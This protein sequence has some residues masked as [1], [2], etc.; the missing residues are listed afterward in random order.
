[1]IKNIIF[2][3]VL[4][5]L[6]ASSGMTA[7]VTA[8]KYDDLL[9]RKLNLEGNLENCTSELASVKAA[10]EEYLYDLKKLRR[11]NKDLL[12]SNILHEKTRVLYHELQDTYEKLL[13]N[14]N[15]LTAHNTSETG[16]L[17]KELADREKDLQ[18]SKQQITELSYDLK[19]REQRVNE[20]EKIIADKE[21]TVKKLK[22]K[23]TGALYGFKDRDLS[24]EVKNGKVYVTMAQNLLFK[25][26]SY[27]VDSKGEDA[28]RKLARVLRDQYDINIMVEGHT[29]DVAISAGTSCMVDNWDLSVLRATAIVRI[30]SS[31]GINTKRLISAGRGEYM[32][33]ATGT[34]SEARRK[35]RRTEIILTP[36]LDEL[37][38]LLEMN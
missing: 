4:I 26:G 38:R 8:K 36:K 13:R 20:L 3:N 5:A 1:M 6:L 27:Q 11:D 10:T 24:I 35:N 12:T 22:D 17:A 32:P 33:V 25:S 18:D 15:A 14:H 30:L 19:L 2:R 9:A 31:E 37:F 29:D 21:K 34:S 23:V 7:C 16:K 28:L